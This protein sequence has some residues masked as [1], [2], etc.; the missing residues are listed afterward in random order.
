[1]GLLIVLAA[2]L[3]V[4]DAGITQAQ[5]KPA[6][7]KASHTKAAGSAKHHARATHKKVGKKTAAKAK[8][9]PAPSLTIVSK[10]PNDAPDFD[11]QARIEEAQALV[12]KQPVLKDDIQADA[13]GKLTHFVW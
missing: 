1:M 5:A 10:T 7:A 13:Q 12:G 8:T 6:H 3:F 2:L 9:G 11:F 4:S